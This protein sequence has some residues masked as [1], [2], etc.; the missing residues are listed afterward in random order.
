[1]RMGQLGRVET[2]V[3]PMVM[4]DLAGAFELH[5][6][7]SNP[8][9]SVLQLRHRSSLLG[10]EPRLV[11]SRLGMEEA[12]IGENA[13]GFQKKGVRPRSLRMIGPHVSRDGSETR[14]N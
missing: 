11:H 14:V 7:C 6:C 8:V 4:G 3:P 2:S 13:S 9:A 5:W 12:F 1:M 10:A